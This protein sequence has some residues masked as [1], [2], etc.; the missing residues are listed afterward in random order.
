VNATL[1]IAI[2]LGLTMLGI[3]AA[4]LKALLTDEAR[5]WLPYLARAFVRA[6]A[7]RLPVEHHERYEEEWLAEV[8]AYSDR[9]LSAVVRAVGLRCHAREM[10]QTLS[11]RRRVPILDRV[12]AGVMLLYLA[13]LFAAIAIAIKLDSR[14]PALIA[15]RRSFGGRTFR[16][17]K[18]RTMRAD[19][20]SSV[21]RF[22]DT[23]RVEWS[24]AI[25]SR[26]TQSGRWPGPGESWPTTTK[27][28]YLWQSIWA[29]RSEGCFQVRADPRVTRVGRV[30][31]A[32]HLDELPMF[33][34]VLRGDMPLPLPWRS[35]V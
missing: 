19:A 3:V 33:I 16:R 34:N 28:A 1:S 2:V 12:V 10:A 9:P 30:L 14:G 22:A 5:A 27:A 6:A 15:V 4:V 25:W 20:A 17:S 26:M 29:T 7:R 21:F 8:E 35:D 18:F 23:H 13:P 11:E 24:P 32:T 31:R